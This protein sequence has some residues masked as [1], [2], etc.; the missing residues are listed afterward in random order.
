[1]G[2]HLSEEKKGCAKVPECPSM[3]KLTVGVCTQDYSG[4]DLSYV[5]LWF[6]TCDSRFSNCTNRKW[7]WTDWMDGLNKWTKSS[8]LEFHAHVLNTC[9]TGNMRSLDSLE[10]KA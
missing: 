8:N 2:N 3:F 9:R 6:Q 10:I 1:M 4:T 5:R 7:C